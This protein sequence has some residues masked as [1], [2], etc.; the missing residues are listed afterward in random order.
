MRVLLCA[1]GGWQR[2]FFS[3]RHHRHHR[4]GSFNNVSQSQHAARWYRYHGHRSPGEFMFTGLIE[5][6]G[7]VVSFQRR[8]EAGILTVDTAIPTAEIA[9][10][11][12][13]AVN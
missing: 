1:K 2:R 8:A 9:I 13:V 5:D 6:T 12:S 7:R 10:G 3:L 11:D 4:H